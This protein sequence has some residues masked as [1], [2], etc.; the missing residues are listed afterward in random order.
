[1]LIVCSTINPK[2]NETIMQSNSYKYVKHSLYISDIKGKALK[3][4][5]VQLYKAFEQESKNI[6]ELTNKMNNI[7]DTLEYINN[8]NKQNTLY[9]LYDDKLIEINR[10]NTDD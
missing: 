7:C 1:M 2:N 4:L 8:I 9:Q 3:R 5:D 6:E 10:I